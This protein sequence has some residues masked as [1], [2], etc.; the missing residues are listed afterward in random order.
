MVKFTTEHFI[1]KAKLK[2]GNKY[3]Y[4]KVDYQGTEEPVIIICPEHGEFWQKPHNHINGCGCPI[5]AGTKKLTT[6]EFIRKA[7]KIHGDKY[8]YSKVEYVNSI[9]P[10]II[11]CPEH[12]EFLQTPSDHLSGKG[13]KKCATK[14]IHDKLR[15]TKQQFIE[16]ARAVHGDKY[17]YDKVEYI[18]ANTKVTII[19]PIHGN[20]Q[21]APISH[22]RQHQGCP[23]CA[24]AKMGEYRKLN[25]ETF[26]EKAIAV[27]GDKYDYSKVNY[28]GNKIPVT[29]I[30]PKHGEFS[31]RPNDILM[32]HGCPECGKELGISEKIV[33]NEI[34]KVF[35]DAEYQKKLSFLKSK[36]SYQTIDIFIPSLNIGIEYQGGQHFRSISKFGGETAY[37]LIIERDER[38]FRK[39]MENGIKLFYISFEKC[40]PDDYFSKVYSTTEELI[41]S[42]INKQR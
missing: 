29:I 39:C 5:C 38:K 28:I 24:R 41:K 25:T 21:M 15:K 27:H 14:L 31:S 16:E 32:G 8:D 23:L 9:T 42:I 6:E 3:D 12:G 17:C 37:L 33:Y 10:I 11:V 2:H 30:C 40:I 18:N 22:V 4:S 35:P 7:R 20:F 19:C 34:K 26:I 36:T 13:C 1:E